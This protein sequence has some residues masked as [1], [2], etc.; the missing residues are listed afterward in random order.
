MPKKHG[1]DTILV[2]VDF[3]ANSTEALAFALD[4]SKRVGIKVK[5]LHVVHD[6]GY[7]PG[8]YVVKGRKKQMRRMEEN[9]SELF[10]SFLAELGKKKKFTQAISNIDKMIV[11][12]LPVTRILEVADELKP[13]MLVMGSQGR[14]GLSRMLLG[15][16]AE[17]VVR[18]STSP[19]TIVK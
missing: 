5:V 8:Y 14:T 3:S 7:A 1:T 16:K 10:D 2:P 19:V 15:S 17:Q 9:A 13:Y 4:L 11:R 12:G 18:L 6:P